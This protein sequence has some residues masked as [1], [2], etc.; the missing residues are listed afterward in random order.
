[1]VS[2]I[3]NIDELIVA[4][5]KTDAETPTPRQPA[6]HTRETTSSEPDQTKSGSHPPIE[7]WDPYDRDGSSGGKWIYGIIGFLLL[8]MLGLINHEGQSNNKTSNTSPTSSQNYS[9]PPNVSVPTVQTS[10]STQSSKLQYTKPSV[11]TDNVLSVSEIRWC[12]RESI[13]IEAMRDIIDNNKGI[14]VFNQIVGDYNSRCGSYRYHKGSQSRAETDV[15]AYR[16]QIV[17]EAIREAKKLDR[18]YQPSYQSISPSVSSRAAPNKPDVQLTKKAQQLLTDLGYDPG[19]VEGDYGRR[20]ADAVRAFQKAQGILVDGW[21]SESLIDK[22]R[23]AK[24]NESNRHQ[25]PTDLQGN[26]PRITKDLNSNENISDISNADR[27]GIIA[28]CQYRGSPA[29]VYSCQQEELSKLKQTGPG[30]NLSG[31]SSSDRA[32]I[33]AACQYRGSPA[34]VYSCQQEELNKLKQTGPGPNL[35]GLSSSDRAGI[36][37]ACQYRGSP[38]NVYSC[39]QEEV[40]KLKQTGPRPNL[41]G[42]SSS[43]RVGIIEVC[44][45]RGSPADVYSCQKE[46]FDK[47]RTSRY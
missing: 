9:N 42:L 18:S 11:G 2:D 33:I 10:N 43:D 45:Y 7:I 41:S 6:Q 1:L 26:V 4:K 29:N 15:E 30:P 39:Q 22:L 44:K 38:A 16:S 25:G 13:R 24:I 32:G 36:I 27:A 17:L 12:I 34:N 8:L 3:S 20:T 46:E 40:N 35:S 47:L 37:A 23:S 28:A 31:L 5:P 14:D 21:V 19:P